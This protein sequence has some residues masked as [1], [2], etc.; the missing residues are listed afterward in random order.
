MVGLTDLVTLSLPE[1]ICLVHYW[2]MQG[3]PC[4][5]PTTPLPNH[6]RRSN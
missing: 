2:G 5:S 1:E 6:Q 4:P 3:A